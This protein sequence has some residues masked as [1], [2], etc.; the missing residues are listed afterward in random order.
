MSILV[1]GTIGRT[2]TVHVEV[3]VGPV[4]ILEPALASGASPHV[5]ILTEGDILGSAPRLLACWTSLLALASV[6]LKD[7]LLVAEE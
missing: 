5:L 7:T 6:L 2:A 1:I 4:K 3:A